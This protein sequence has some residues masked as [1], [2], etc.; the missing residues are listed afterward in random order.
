MSCVFYLIFSLSSC[1]C[2]FC[3]SFCSFAILFSSAINLSNL[4]SPSTSCTRFSN[5][6]IYLI[7]SSLINHPPINRKIPIYPR[8][9]HPCQTNRSHHCGCPPRH[10]FVQILP[11]ILLLVL[12]F[13]RDSD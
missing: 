12:Y 6:C 7:S 2:L 5:S 9:H 11:I 4:F 13:F 3:F 1:L 10:V 8:C